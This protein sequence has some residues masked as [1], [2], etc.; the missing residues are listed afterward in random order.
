MVEFLASKHSIPIRAVSF[1]VF[2]LADGQRVLVRDEREA[3]PEEVPTAAKYSIDSV[4]ANAGGPESPDGR[5]MRVV[6]AAGER[7]GLYPKPYRYSIMLTPPQNKTRFLATIWRPASGL[8]M[9]YSAD[10][11]AEFF[12][13]KPEDVRAR[14][15]PEELPLDSDEQAE[16]WA[17]N[18]EALFEKLA[19][20]HEEAR[21]DAA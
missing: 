2:A 3:G 21:G 12:P 7:V 14:L 20:E 16:L 15:G 11:F 4:L 19:K 1:E 10:A 13:F 6:A 17:A 8:R 9:I 18:L 5:R